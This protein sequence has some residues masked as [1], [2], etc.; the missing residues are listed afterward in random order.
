MLRTM[1]AEWTPCAIASVQAA[2]TAGSPSVSTAVRMSTICRLPSSRLAN[3]RRTRSIAAGSTQSL[4]G[5]PL[6][7]APGL[8]A[9]TGGRW[10][11]GHRLDEI[12][13]AH[14][15]EAAIV[16]AILADE[17]GLHRR[18]HVVVDA[19]PAGALE[20]GERAVVG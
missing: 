12:V 9:S 10:R 16:E 17:D 11:T 19:A 6:R 20:Q 4:N 5:A 13:A 3:L 2:S 1:S 14:L 15:Q 8:R 7:K 18:L